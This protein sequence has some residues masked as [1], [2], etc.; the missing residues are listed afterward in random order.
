MDAPESLIPQPHECDD[1][2]YGDHP[3]AHVEDDVGRRRGAIDAVFA[4]Q[5]VDLGI[6]K[7]SMNLYFKIEIILWSLKSGKALFE[8]KK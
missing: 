4:V 2:A 5:L 3:Q 1:E 7:R 8:A 6:Q